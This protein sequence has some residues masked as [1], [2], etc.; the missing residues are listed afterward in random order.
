MGSGFGRSL[1]T[2]VPEVRLLG[3]A[4]RLV[5]YL[6]AHSTKVNRRVGTLYAYLQS[7]GLGYID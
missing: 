3:K 6:S 5:L 4:E 7:G 2:G 1:Q